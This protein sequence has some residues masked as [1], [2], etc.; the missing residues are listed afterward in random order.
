[1]AACLLCHLFGHAES[2]DPPQLSLLRNSWSQAKNRAAQP[3][4]LA[5]QKRLERLQKDLSSSGKIEE[6][7][8]VKKEVEK[9]VADPNLCAE[10]EFDPTPKGSEQVAP[11]RKTWLESRAKS[12]QPTLVIYSRELEKLQDQLANAGELEGALAVKRELDRIQRGDKTVPAGA[13][14]PG[15]V[16]E[17]WK[18]ASGSQFLFKPD[19][20]GTQANAAG[21]EWPTAWQEGADG[22]VVVDGWLDDVEAKLYFRFEKAKEGVFGSSPDRLDKSISAVE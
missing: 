20:T 19:G 18:T 6:A 15:F 17:R 11:L 10:G 8:T 2:A 12:A 13:K 22:L 4:D 21:R 5:Y 1:V 16:G 9:L 3:A 14:S 7:I